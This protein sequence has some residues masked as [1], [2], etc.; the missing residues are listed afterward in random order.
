MGCDYSENPGGVKQLFVTLY[1]MHNLQSMRS[2][3]RRAKHVNSEGS[4]YGGL[5]RSP[6]KRLPALT[7]LRFL[8]PAEE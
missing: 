4:R 6:G 3:R 2:T 7:L 8:G 5:G 1:N